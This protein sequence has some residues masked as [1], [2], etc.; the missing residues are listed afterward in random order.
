MYLSE[1][2]PVRAHVESLVIWHSQGI[3]VSIS[4]SLALIVS[5]WLCLVAIHKISRI[6]FSPSVLN[7]VDDDE[8]QAFGRDTAKRASGRIAECGLLHLAA[9]DRQVIGR[10]H[11]RSRKLCR[12]SSSR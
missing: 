2:L 3:Y 12:W 1:L 8:Q 4:C 10:A 9:P 6:P 11:V 7:N 5:T